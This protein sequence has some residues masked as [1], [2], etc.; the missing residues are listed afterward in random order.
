[1]SVSTNSGVTGI[2]GGSGSSITVQ[3]PY[4]TG[5][6]TTDSLALQ[7]MAANA[8]AGAII[9]FP[10][11]Q[12]YVVYPGMVVPKAGQI[13]KLN[14]STLQ[15]ANQITTTLNAQLNNGALF[16]T[17][18]AADI[19]K[20]MVGMGVGVGTSDRSTGW[21]A[22]WYPI[23][24][25]D[26]NN[27]RLYL[28]DPSSNWTSITLVN[29]AG[30]VASLPIGTPVYTCG[31][32]FGT[33]GTYKQASTDTYILPIDPTSLQNTGLI[34]AGATIT[35]GT[36]GDTAVVVSYAKDRIYV[37]NPQHSAAFNVSSFTCSET[38]TISG[39]TVATTFAQY[40][41]S[42]NGSVATQPRGLGSYPFKGLVLEKAVFDG[43]K[44]NQTA[45]MRWEHMTEI[46]WVACDSLVSDVFIKNSAGEGMLVGGWDGHIRNFKA[47]DL[48]GNGLHFGDV[49]TV[50]GCW[51]WTV[52][53]VNINGAAKDSG[54]GHNDGCIT[55][56]NNTRNIRGSDFLLSNAGGT[57]NVNGVGIGG[58][59]SYDNSETSWTN[60]KIDNCVGG[61]FTVATPTVD[62]RDPATKW[63]VIYDVHFSHIQVTN[64]GK[65][66][67]SNITQF[68]GSYSGDNAAQSIIQDCSLVDINFY[69][70]IA[71]YGPMKRCK[72]IGV[73]HYSSTGFGTFS[74]A[75]IR[76]MIDSTTEIEVTDDTTGSGA[77]G[78]IKYGGT[79]W[80]NFILRNTAR[81]GNYGFN[82]AQLGATSTGT[83]VFRNGKCE[84]RAIDSYTQ[85]FFIAPGQNFAGMQ[86]GDCD[87]DISLDVNRWSPPT[88][89]IGIQVFNPTTKTNPGWL[90]FFKPRGNISY[91]ISSA[92]TGG[93]VN[94]TVTNGSVTGATTNTNG[95][96]YTAG[97]YYLC[98]QNAVGKPAVVKCVLSGTDL[99][100]ATYTVVEGGTNFSANGTQAF[101]FVGPQIFQMNSGQQNVKIFDPCFNTG[102]NRAPFSWGATQ[103][104]VTVFGG[105]YDSGA[106]SVPASGSAVFLR[107]YTPNSRSRT[108]VTP[109]S[110]GS[111][112]VVN[113]L[114]DNTTIVV[115][116]GTV[117]NVEVSFNGGGTFDSIA[118]STSTPVIFHAPPNAQ[119][120]LTYTVAPT[121]LRFGA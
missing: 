24:S 26:T 33:R 103:T 102:G 67:N 29:S 38:L 58:I 16:I 46:D 8:P 39:T 55:Y 90:N 88:G 30:A 98:I 83:T 51:N 22:I 112:F 73:R 78:L 69:E 40:E 80:D 11:N 111:G 44:Q 61:A 57:G 66:S 2:G 70:T 95:S 13:W 79:Q 4:A 77:N 115:T 81:G 91:I 5:N 99:S 105:W 89:F 119:L 101:A 45:T 94:Y 7:S 56:S 53:G 48:Q 47:E 9:E 72:L 6:A 28:A 116:G 108:S 12:L 65:A 118:S 31:A 68:G 121:V 64:C 52:T 86:Y 97:T 42:G 19:N 92:G 85:G 17:I 71:N 113:T 104:R 36:T 49:D 14:G 32:V 54:M 3:A 15:R 20:F 23:I 106:I 50:T 43:N 25:I 120:R 109:A 21:T 93:I 107:G 35:G 82:W 27:N 41:P 87:F 60:G 84:D 18:P 10:S 100:T 76:G 34:V 114:P 74:A 96:G 63:S 110:S 75:T 37:T 59:N 117:T 1:M 62:P